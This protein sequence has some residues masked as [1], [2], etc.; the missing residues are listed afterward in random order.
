[1]LSP[2]KGAKKERALKQKE[3]DRQTIHQGRGNALTLQDALSS[4]RAQKN[5]KTRVC[6]GGK[7]AGRGKKERRDYY[8][9]FPRLT[10]KRIELEME[11]AVAGGGSLSGRIGGKVKIY[12]G[13][14]GGPQA[15]LGH[16]GLLIKG[17]RNVPCG[18]VLGDVAEEHLGCLHLCG[19]AGEGVQPREKKD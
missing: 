6:G 2:D 11:I 9:H 16:G 15:G 8:E 1:L 5:N 19:G 13:R 3:R 10:G 7:K 18:S 12:D 14:R 17:N 4:R